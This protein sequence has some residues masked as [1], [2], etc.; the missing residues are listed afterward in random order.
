MIE[1]PLRSEEDFNVDWNT[2]VGLLQQ[3]LPYRSEVIPQ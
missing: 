1:S 3:L 2:S